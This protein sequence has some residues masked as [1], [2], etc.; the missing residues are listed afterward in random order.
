MCMENVH[1]LKGATLAGQYRDAGRVNSHF[2]QPN[3]LKN[4]R[5]HSASHTVRSRILARIHERLQ[6]EDIFRE[7]YTCMTAWA[8]G[9]GITTAEALELLDD[10]TGCQ[11]LLV[12]YG[13]GIALIHTEEELDDIKARM[14]PPQIMCFTSHDERKYTLVYNNLMPGAAVFGWGEQYALAVDALFL[15]EDGIEDIRQPMLANIVTWILWNSPHRSLTMKS[16]VDIVTA[17]GQCIDGYAVNIVLPYPTARAYKITFTRDAVETEEIGESPGSYLRQLNIID[18]AYAE[19]GKAIA[20]W[21][22]PYRRFYRGYW[23]Y[24]KE[25]LKTID[26]DITAYLPYTDKPIHDYERIHRVILREIA[27]P[28]LAPHYLNEVVG[29]VCTALTTDRN[30]SVAVGLVED[31]RFTETLIF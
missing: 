5:K 28:A 24:Y 6:R 21:R 18:P 31:S 4:R 23:N 17:C 27:G 25:R 11:S 19:K 2:L 3:V 13:N 26:R 10:N 14:T 12:R 9:A 30:M 1:I 7:F 16:A 8:Q 15:T 22:L 29:A 20:R